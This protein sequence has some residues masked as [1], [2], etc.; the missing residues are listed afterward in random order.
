MIFEDGRMN[1]DPN[2]DFDEWDLEGPE[3]LGLD[4]VEDIIGSTGS[5]LEDSGYFRRVSPE[6]MERDLDFGDTN[7]GDTNWR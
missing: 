1:I 6:L 3:S 4:A 7:W 2:F 5:S